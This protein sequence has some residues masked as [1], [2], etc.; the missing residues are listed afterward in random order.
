VCRLS[1]ELYDKPTHF[2]LELV[3]NADDNTYQSE[4]PPS[5][6]F[7]YKKGSLR[8]DCNEVG[9]TES[10]VKAICSIGESTK[11]GLDHSTRYIGEKGIGF[12]SVFKVAS[13]VHIFSGNFK[14]KLR[15]EGVDLIAP[16][17]ADFPEPTLPGYTSFYLQL[18]ENCE[19]EIIREIRAL[20]PTML[21]FLRQL[22]QINLTV[23]QADGQVWT[24]KL[25]RR[26]RVADGS[27]ITTLHRGNSI[28]EYI[29]IKHHALQLPGEDKRR[30]CSESEVMLA[31]P[32]SDIERTPTG[33]TES[34]YAFL[35]IRDYGFKV[36]IAK[37]SYGIYK[38]NIIP[39]PSPRRLLTHDQSRRYHG[40]SLE[41][42]PP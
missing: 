5:L 32:I 1:R 20:D 19:D 42:C 13:I 14:F 26:D 15:S 34:V 24:R 40:N 31:F 2:L 16:I 3:Q 33:D 17:W 11:T 36:G 23:T 35:P 27:L 38:S 28:S 12:K 25:W 4:S 18:S 6:S 10:N 29:V 30:G 8:V 21:M 39:V 41:L 22:R 7:T 37:P 9:F